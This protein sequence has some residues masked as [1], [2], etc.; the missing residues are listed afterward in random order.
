[1]QVD[2]P[3]LGRNRAHRLRRDLPEVAAEIDGG[4]GAVAIERLVQQSHRVDAPL[5]VAEREARAGVR[6]PRALQPEQ[7]GDHLQVVLHPVV[8]FPQQ[9]VLVLQ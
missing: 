1:M 7:A 6:M 2:P 5:H 8:H 9:R 3:G 4:D